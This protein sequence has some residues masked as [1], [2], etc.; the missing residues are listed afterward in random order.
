MVEIVD[1]LLQRA[2][3]LSRIFSDQY[4]LDPY[5][6]EATSDVGVRLELLSLLASC[7]TPVIR[8]TLKKV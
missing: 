1:G 2:E 3:F 4:S 8:I 6:F 5:K 7:L